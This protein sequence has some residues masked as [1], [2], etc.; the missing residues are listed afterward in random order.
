MK[1][2]NSKLGN[3]LLIASALKDKAGSIP[4]PVW[5]IGGGLA[6]FV[7]YKFFSG[8]AAVAEKLGLKDDKFDDRAN[9]YVHSDDANQKSFS[10]N[11]WQE[12]QKELI[13][14]KKQL[15]ILTKDEA[16]I[17]ATKINKSW[18][19]WG[20]DEGKVY[21]TMRIIRSKADL[22]RVSA[23]YF[24]NFKKDLLGE[25]KARLSSKEFTIILDI[26]KKLPDFLVVSKNK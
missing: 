20:D 8:A 10:L 25:L 2:K 18:S 1:Q 7:V 22:S 23:S 4:T 11:Y 21:G 3:P 16:K 17:L 14:Q 26:I 13:T 15:L 12:K 19:V 5:I 6:L 24:L 9:D